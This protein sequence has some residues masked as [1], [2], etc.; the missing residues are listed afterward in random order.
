MS[1]FFWDSF[2]FS[3]ICYVTINSITDV[4]DDAFKNE[5]NIYFDRKIKKLKHF[6]VMVVYNKPFESKAWS[7]R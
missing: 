2:D 6:I 1:V 3:A 5:L 7:W 4:W